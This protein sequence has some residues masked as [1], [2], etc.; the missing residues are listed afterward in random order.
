MS[1]TTTEIHLS[2]PKK[3][4][5]FAVKVA[6]L[7]KKGD[8][9]VLR[10]ELGSGKTTFCK[11]F[12]KNLIREKEEIISPTFNIVKT[13]TSKKNIEIWHFDLYR[14]KNEDEALEIGLDDAFS[15]AISLIEWPEKIERLLPDNCLDISISYG[16]AANERFARIDTGNSHFNLKEIL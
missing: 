3:T 10:G 8:V 12:I 15:N 13:Y 6:K 7:S 9:I 5:D 4:Y 2:S 16:K 11:G 14:L 1:S